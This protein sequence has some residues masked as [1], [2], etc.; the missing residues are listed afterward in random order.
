MTRDLRKRIEKLESQIP[1]QPT[2]QDMAGKFLQRLLSA[3]SPIIWA[4][5]TENG[6]ARRGLFAGT[7]ICEPV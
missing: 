5:P 4:N 3:G 1:P 7:W 6:L 2:E